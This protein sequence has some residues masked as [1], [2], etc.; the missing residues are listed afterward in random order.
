MKK[1]I[2]LFLAACLY[3]SCSNK[4]YNTSG[5]QSKQVTVDGKLTEWSNPLRFYDQEQE[6][7]I[8]LPTIIITSILFAAYQMISFRQKS[9][10]PDLNSR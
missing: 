8:I 5:W 10:V 1:I 2:F 4:I 3:I 6:S 7:V 9:S